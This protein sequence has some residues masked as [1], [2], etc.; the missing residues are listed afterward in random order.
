MEIKRYDSG[1]LSSNMY[2]LADNDH[3]IIIDPSMDT[4]PGENLNVEMM[5]ITHEHYDHISGV[6]VW[7]ERFKVPLLCSESCAN[8][9]TDPKTNL[10]RYFDEICEMQS[11]MQVG[12]LPSI[13]YSY[14]CK[15]EKIFRDKTEFEWM[16]HS[17]RLIEIPGHSP[18]SIGVYVDYTHFFSG[19]S[20]F[21]DIEIELRF[22]G[23]SRKQWIE[24]GEPRIKALPKGTIIWPGHFEAFRIF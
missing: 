13:D 6:N 23:G 21:K 14:K 2:V 16:G 19:D 5:I 12:I 8:R 4:L 7:K 18:G 22:P 15:A 3:A 1:I 10:A 24:V 9:I 17:I 11:W 20:F